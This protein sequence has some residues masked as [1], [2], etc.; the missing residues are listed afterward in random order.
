MSLHAL[1]TG[2]LRG[3]CR[4]GA[5]DGIQCVGENPIDWMMGSRRTKALWLQMQLFM[6][7]QSPVLLLYF[8]AFPPKSVWVNLRGKMLMQ[9]IAYSKPWKTCA[10]ARNCIVGSHALLCHSAL[11]NPLPLSIQHPSRPVK[12]SPQHLPFI[13]IFITKILGVKTHPRQCVQQVFHK[14]PL[15]IAKMRYVR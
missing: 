6:D 11:Q 12:F 5:C 8:V 13:Y 1:C 14:L 15:H 3:M 10:R 9:T 7:S 2:S 4:D